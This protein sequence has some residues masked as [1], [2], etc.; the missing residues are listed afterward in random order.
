MAAGGLSHAMLAAIA[1]P[2]S[3]LH[4]VEFIALMAM[5]FATV[6]FSVDAMLPAMPEIAATLS[7][8]APNLAQLVVTAFV[9]GMGLGTFVTGPLS[10]SYGRKPVILAGAGLYIVGAALAWAAPTIELLLAARLV[11]GLGAAGPRVVTLAIIRDLYSGERMAR[12]MSFVLM[13]FA[14]VPALAP[15]LGAGIIAVAGWREIF[16]AFIAFAAVSS[17]WMLLRLRET[18]PRDRRLPFRRESFARALS[19]IAGNPRVRLA[20]LVQGLCFGML[21]TMLSTVQQV[22]DLT[23]GRADS[24]PYWFAAIAVVAAGANLANA[25]AV[26]RLGMRRLITGALAAQVVLSG[27]M[28]LLGLFPPAEPVFFGAFVIWQA[29]ILVQTALTLGNVNALAMEP[30]GHIAGVASSVI[31][32]VA[33]VVAVTLAVPTGLLFDGTPLPIAAGIFV[34]ASVALGFMVRIRTLEARMCA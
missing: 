8:E 21:F 25:A 16:A 30:L 3:R 13:V 2:P 15:L 11:Q 12:T 18:L 6:A 34:M 33:T 27:T 26:M 10:D 32:A 17:L 14:V 19:E 31:G 9:L 28:I 7:P 5:I 1:M 4:P 24:F 22:Y 23:F 20:I 29:S